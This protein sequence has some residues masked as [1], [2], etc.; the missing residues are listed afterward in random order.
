MFLVDRR[1]AVVPSNNASGYH[2]EGKRPDNSDDT[3]GDSDEDDVD[4][5]DD[6]KH[7]EPDEG[8]HARWR[9]HGIYG[10]HLVK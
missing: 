7:E 5:N 1:L 4:D 2:A 10:R 9:Y 6:E 3:D 8:Q